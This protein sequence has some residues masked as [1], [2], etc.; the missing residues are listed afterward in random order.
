MYLAL[1]FEEETLPEADAP[2]DLLHGEVVDTVAV[3]H[4]LPRQDPD[5]SHQHSLGHSRIPIIQF[6]EQNLELFYLGSLKDD[7][8]GTESSGMVGKDKTIK[9]QYFLIGPW[10]N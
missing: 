6:I 1:T 9:V 5:L 10:L 3:S 7:P 2:A 4:L 8:D